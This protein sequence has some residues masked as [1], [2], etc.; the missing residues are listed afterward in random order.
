MKARDMVENYLIGLG[1]SLKKTYAYIPDEEYEY[2]S[3]AG[4]TEVVKLGKY[5]VK[6]NKIIRNT[7]EFNWVT[8]IARSNFINNVT[9][10]GD[11][12]KS[13]DKVMGHAVLYFAEFVKYIANNIDIK[14][15]FAEKLMALANGA[16]DNAAREIDGVL[17]Q[18]GKNMEDARARAAEH[19]A[20]LAASAIADITRVEGYRVT[21]YEQEGLFG[22][23]YTLRATPITMGEDRA[24]KRMEIA[25]GAAAKLEA[26]F[27]EDAVDKAVE[28]L[29][30]VRNKLVT[31]FNEKLKELLGVKLDEY[32]EE[33]LFD[34][35]GNNVGENPTIYHHYLDV[36]NELEEDQIEDFKKATEYY[37]IYLLGDLK[38][39]VEDN[40]FKAFTKEG[41]ID[42]KKI[43]YKTYVAL[44]SDEFGPGS[45][46]G[47]RIVSYYQVGF[48]ENV[49][50]KEN[51]KYCDIYDGY[52]ERINNC[53]YL[54]DKEKAEINKVFD[55]FKTK[56]YKN[57]N[58]N[59]IDFILSAVLLV[60]GIYA[61][62]TSFRYMGLFS[63]FY[64]SAYLIGIGIPLF[65]AVA[66]F[67]ISVWKKKL[68]KKIVQVALIV[69]CI[70]VPV[71]LNEPI[72]TEAAK[73]EG[74]Y[75]IQLRILEEDEILYL[76]EGE[77]IPLDKVEKEGYVFNGWKQGSSYVFGDEYV[78][79][80]NCVYE[81]DIYSTSENLT[82]V[83]FK[84]DNGQKN[85]VLQLPLY[86][87]IP[88][89]PAP[90]KKGYRFDGWYDEQ[91]YKKQYS[92]L[93]IKM[94]NPTYR[95]MWIEE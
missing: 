89:V 48:N 38:K 86:S 78:E 53:K 88:N 2:S 10:T 21:G 16:M 93:E 94:E 87:D 30:K 55:D 40:M 68:F 19:R 39:R 63:L 25:S 35:E 73:R 17:S 83:T 72:A 85:I 27:E 84:P 29:A 59:I 46:L 64:D 66:W 62:I 3:K 32:F 60:L 20:D 69:G 47:K 13:C 12:M 51:K 15:D 23:T 65:L 61:I 37:R 71:F 77:K 31:E 24:R 33:K 49:S 67:V 75:V 22:D 95:A 36:V 41:V 1:I 9:V 80:S 34:R 92:G 57:R 11:I 4:K 18:Y 81:A 58:N 7:R 54:T 8:N 26:F 76:K 6:L 82:T 91:L 52:R 14:A 56:T 74:K 90:E 42:Y 50:F 44:K 70:M 45:N 79:T 5:D 28:A 43:D